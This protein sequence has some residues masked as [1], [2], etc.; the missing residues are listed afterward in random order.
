MICNFLSMSDISGAVLEDPDSTVHHV[1]CSFVVH[2]I[3]SSG[4]RAPNH[5]QNREWASDTEPSKEESTEE[6]SLP[7]CITVDKEM[8]EAPFG[9]HPYHLQASNIA[10]R[11]QWINAINTALRAYQRERL[12]RVREKGSALRICQLRVRSFYTGLLFQTSTSV[13]VAVNFFVTVS[14]VFWYGAR[15][16]RRLP[17]CAVSGNSGVESKVVY[18]ARCAA[19]TI[20]PVASLPI[21]QSDR[22]TPVRHSIM[23]LKSR[24]LRATVT[25]MSDAAVL[26]W[27][28]LGELPI[29]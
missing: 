15:R 12:E 11:D 22:L 24:W 25:C 1:E 28:R 19:H 2:V 14:A 27:R 18:R 21:V 20:P 13:L 23:E 5:D 8:Q 26:D 9:P 7:G 6:H 16:H 3:P 17:L 29:A 4:G 10:E